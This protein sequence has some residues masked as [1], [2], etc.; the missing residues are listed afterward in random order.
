[1]LCEPKAT[2]GMDTLGSEY[3]DGLYSYA[4]VLTHNHAEAEDLVQETYVRAIPAVGR[5][6]PESNIK[7][8]LFKILRNVWFN[9]LRKRRSDPQMVQTDMEGGSVENLVNPGKDSYE[10]YLGEV[11]VQRVRAAIEQLSLEFREVILL[12]EFEELSYQEIA[13]LLDCPPGTVMS[14]L[15]RARSKLRVLL[16]STP[17]EREHAG[18]QSLQRPQSPHAG[19]G[20]RL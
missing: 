5:L 2:A 7:A 13:S 19:I 4:L 20:E 10:I 18:T 9:Q 16:S 14:R 3:I 6:K 15:A 11:E 12:R 8:W 17:A 1:M